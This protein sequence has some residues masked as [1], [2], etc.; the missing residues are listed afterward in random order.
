MEA[1]RKAGDRVHRPM[2]E[3]WAVSEVPQIAGDTV[4]PIRIYPTRSPPAMLSTRTTS[5]LTA[6]ALCTGSAIAMPP[7]VRAVR[8]DA[9]PGGTGTSWQQ[10]YSSLQD[11]LDEAA[12]K[13]GTITQIWVAGGVYHPSAERFPGDPRSR[14]FAMVDGVA[15]YGGFEGSEDAVEKRSVAANVTILSGM[16]LSPRPNHIVT[17]DETAG[18]VLD[19]FTIRGGRAAG[20]GEHSLGGGVFI[21]GGSIHI[22]HCTIVENEALGG[23]GVYV[24]G[25]APSFFRSTIEGNTVFTANVAGA[26]MLVSAGQVSITESTFAENMAIGPTAGGGIGITGGSVRM[27]RGRVIANHAENGAALFC[28]GG[29]FTA[30]STLFRDNLGGLVGDN[31]TLINCTV[32]RNPAAAPGVWSG[33]NGTG[34]LVNSIVWGNA[35]KDW[36]GIVP[37]VWGGIAVAYS[38]VEPNTIGPQLIGPGLTRSNP[39]LTGDGR[40]KAHSPAIDAGSNAALDDFPGPDLGGYVRFADD[41]GTPDRGLG[42][43][44]VVDMG[45]FEFQGETCYANCDGSTAAPVLTASDFVCFMNRF[46]AG[47]LLANCDGSTAP[48]VLNVADFSC[49]VAKFIAG[50]P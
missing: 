31:L 29:E 39:V 21:T 49:F 11:A 27:L 36:E 35:E 25:G 47:D 18:A 7:N 43:A 41:A 13:P 20:A 23:G 14:T 3:I 10:A 2:N 15:V 30:V 33:V 12:A 5:I 17:A 48:P 40:I 32:F 4:S 42:S 19:G 22:A 26:G 34:A 6:I 46:A 38:C 1:A 44:P 9:G 28:T 45:A 16:E 24:A 37:Q 8:H 50:C